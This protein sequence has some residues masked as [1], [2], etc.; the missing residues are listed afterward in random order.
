MTPITVCSRSLSLNLDCHKLLILGASRT[1]LAY[2]GLSKNWAPQM[3]TDGQC[4]H[5][6]NGHLGL[7]MHIPISDTHTHRMRSPLVSY[8]CWL[9]DTLNY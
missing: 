3:P 7:Y 2:M 5:R 8:F 1:K 4:H 9:K 6:E